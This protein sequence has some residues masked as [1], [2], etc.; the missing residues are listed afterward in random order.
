MG[1]VINTCCKRQTIPEYGQIE[2]KTLV[3]NEQIEAM[4]DADSFIFI[5]K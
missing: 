5:I 2:I 1:T 4:L 3:Q